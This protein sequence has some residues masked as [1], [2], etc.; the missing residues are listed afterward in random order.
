MVLRA[1]DNITPLY[2]FIVI[3]LLAL[4]CGTC[5]LLLAISI[6]LADRFLITVSLFG[7]LPTF[8]LYIIGIRKLAAIAASRL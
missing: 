4:C 2:G 3:H 7:L 6:R 5:G 8:V 1:F